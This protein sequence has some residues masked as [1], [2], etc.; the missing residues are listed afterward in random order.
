ML[1]VSWLF[2]APVQ[3]AMANSSKFIMF[4]SPLP[5]P[6]LPSPFLLQLRVVLVLISAMKQS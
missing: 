2:G 4:P 1:H 3:N 5:S 6:P